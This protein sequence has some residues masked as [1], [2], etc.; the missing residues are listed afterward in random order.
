[1]IRQIFEYHPVLAYR[2]I[3]GITSRLDR[4]DGG[5]YLIR[6]NGQGFRCDHDFVP[7]K[8]PGEKRILLFGDS[9]TAGDGVSNGKRFGD[10]LEDRIPRA[11]VYN[12][13]LPGS[14]TDQHYLA[15]REFGAA[16]E[17]DVLVIAIL[18]EN[19]RRVAARYRFFTNDEGK[20]VCFAK[21][22]FEVSGDGASDTGSAEDTGP[23]LRGVPVPRQ[24]LS[25]D[26]IPPAD[27]P[28]VDRGVGGKYGR[29]KNL[30]IRLGLKETAQRI[31]RFDPVP[32]YRNPEARPWR[33][34]ELILKSWISNHP[35]PVLLLPIPLYQHVEG[36][37]PPGHYQAR[38]SALA[39]ELG[40]A[41][42]DVLPDLLKMPL[43]ERK[44]LR[45]A[46]D[47]HLTEAGHEAFAELIQP[48]V[49]SLLDRS[50]ESP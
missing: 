47:N 6:A 13:G 18:V 21:P 30:V 42:Y 16:L 34:M 23:E 26:D 48:H 9:F 3:P 39:R 12:F 5:G 43:A 36:I 14:G 44:R 4:P 32:E 20:R 49:E 35:K 38:F 25:E 8:E 31:T 2:F 24:P 22:Y 41:Y 46:S 50:E 11:Q 7:Q 40:C 10:L 1:M 29:L 37:S 45:F 33:T 15:Y 17:H 28:F 27:R 19:I